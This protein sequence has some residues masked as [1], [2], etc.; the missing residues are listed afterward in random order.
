MEKGERLAKASAE[1]Q[2]LKELTAAEIRR[3][4]EET[5]TQVAR[6][7]ELRQSDRDLLEAMASERTRA[8]EKFEATVVA[9]FVQVN[10]FRGSLDDLGKTMA[11]RRELETA[12][13]GIKAETL[14]ALDAAK[15][16]TDELRTQA[17]EL[18]SRIDVGPA[19]LDSL[20]SRAD[21]SVGADARGRELI[22]YAFSA[23]VLVVALGGVLVAV[24]AR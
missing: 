2:A 6:W 14:T 15:V 12:L 10:E 3:L 7:Q 8:I 9:R 18:R 11:T 4:D 19:A 23:A 21:R 13:A 5:E 24:L 16:T 20:Q 1:I 22:A 17:Q